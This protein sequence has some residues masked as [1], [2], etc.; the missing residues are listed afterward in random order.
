MLQQQIERFRQKQMK[1]HELTQ[2]LLEHAAD[3]SFERD[4]KYGTSLLMR[5]VLLKLQLE[6]V[7][8]APAPTRFA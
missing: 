5:S 8:A 4:V 7:A 3:Y 2:P 1:L 6:N